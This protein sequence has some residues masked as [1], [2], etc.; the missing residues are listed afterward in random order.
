MASNAIHSTTLAELAFLTQSEVFVGRDLDVSAIDQATIHSNTKLVSSSVITNDGGLTLLQEQIEAL[1]AADFVSDDVAAALT[2]GATVRVHQGHAGGGRSGKVY[3]YLGTGRSLDGQPITFDLNTIDF[4]DL[5]LWVSANLDIL[6]TGNNLSASDSVAVGGIVASNDVR[7]DTAARITRADLTAGAVSLTAS[8]SGTIT[9]VIDSVVESSGDSAFGEGTTLAVNGTIAANSVLGSAEALLVDSVITTTAA[10]DSDGAVHVSAANAAQIDA[11]N[12]SVTH[13]GDGAVGAMLAFNSIGYVPQN[14]FFNSV[15]ALLGSSIANQQALR[16]EASVKD[17][18]ITAAGDV[19]VTAESTAEIEA[20]L[21]N[22]VTSVASGLIGANGF[23]ASALVASNRVASVVDAFVEFSPALPVADRSVTAAGDFTVAA[24]DHAAVTADVS[25]LSDSTATNDLG[26]SQVNALI[27]TL[28]NQY[29]YSSESGAKNLS[30]GDLVRVASTYELPPDAVQPPSDDDEFETEVVYKYM[31]PAGSVDLGATDYSNFGLWMKLNLFNVLP[32]GLNFSDSNSVGS[33]GLVVRNDVDGNATA[34]LE[35]AGAT[36]TGD[37]AVSATGDQT[38]RATTDSTVSSSGGSAFGGGTSLAVN[39]VIVTNNMLGDAEA[40]VRGSSITTLGSASSGAAGDFEVTADNTASFIA[41]NTSSTDSG[42]AS[43][44]VTLAYNRLGYSPSN[45]LFTSVEAIFGIV[46]GGGQP[47]GAKAWVEDTPIDVAGDLSVTAHNEAL[48]EAAVTNATASNA[49]AI[50]GATGAAAAAI[51]ASNLVD[52]DAAA[53]VNFTDAYLSENDLAHGAV[54]VAGGITVAAKDRAGIQADTTLE[55]I[56]ETTN[57]GLLGV[58]RDWASQLDGIYSFTSLSGT[59]SLIPGVAVRVAPGHSAGGV[60][61]GIYRYIGAP[62][63]IALGEENYARTSDWTRVTVEAGDVLPDLGNISD[64]DSIAVGLLLV[65]NDV[66]SD[67]DAAVTRTYMNASGNIQV[68]SLE[69]TDMIATASALVTSD[70]GGNDGGISL[71]LSGVIATNNVLGSAN[72]TIDASVIHAGGDF[73]IHAENRSTIDAS[74][75]AANESGDGAAGLTAAFNMLGVQ[76]LGLFSTLVDTVLGVNL[77]LLLEHPAEVKATASNTPIHAGGDLNVHADNFAELN[78]YT[79]NKVESAA[80][81]ITGSS[82]WAASMVIAA[83][84]VVS[85][86]EAGIAFAAG[87]SDR[88]V[89]AG[90]SVDV[91]AEN[92]AGNYSETYMVTASE[93]VNDG[94]AG[95]AKNVL[96]A[97]DPTPFDFLSSDGVQDIEFGQTVRLSKSHSGGGTPGSRYRYMGDDASVDLATADYDDKGYWREVSLVRLIETGGNVSESDSMAVG[98]ILTRNDVRSDVDAYLTDAVVTAADQVSV[99]ALENAT[100]RATV[101]AVATSSGGSAFGEGQSLAVNGVIAVN[102]VLSDAQAIVTGGSITTTAGDIVVHSENASFLNARNKSS[103]ESGDTGVGVTLA[104][105]TI[106][107]ETQD[108][109]TQ[110]FDALLGTQWLNRENPTKVHAI[111]DSTPLI[112]GGGISVTADNHATLRSLVSNEVASVAEAPRGAS[113]KAVGAVLSSNL[114]LIDTQASI[115]KTDGGQG[116]ATTQDGD[117]IVAATE[118]AA[119]I[120]HTQLAATSSATNDGGLSRILNKVADFLGYDF[121]DRSGTRTVA[122]GKLVLRDGA[123]FTSM[124]FAESITRG[125]RVLLEL[126]VEGG[127]KGDVF[128]FIGADDLEAVELDTFDYGD[129]AKWRKLTGDID[130]IYKYVGPSGAVNLG[131][132]DYADT[133]MWTPLPSIQPTELIPGLSLNLTDSDSHGFGGMIVRNAVESSVAALIDNYTL[134]AAGNV[135][136]EAIESSQVLAQGNATVTSSG[137]SIAGEGASLAL[138][139]VIATNAVQAAAEARIDRSAVTTTAGGDSAGDVDVVSRNNARIAAKTWST[140]EANGH[141]IGVTLAFNSVGYVPQNFLFNTIDTL[142][143]TSL[144]DQNPVTTH[145]VIQGTSVNAAGDVHVESL[146]DGGIDA[147]ITGAGKTLSVTPAGGSGTL[148]VGAILSMNKVATDTLATINSPASLTVGGD[149]E[150]I[151][152]DQARIVADV[153]QSSIAVGAGT[154]DSSAVAAGISWARNEVENHVRARIVGAGTQAAPASVT[155]GDLLVTTLRRGK[156]LATVTSTAVGVSAS[157]TNA[158]GISG[159]GSIGVNNLSGTAAAEISGSVIDVHAGGATIASDDES[160]IDALVRSIAGSVAISGTKS[161]AFALSLSVAKN[162]IGWQRTSETANHLSTDQP[163]FLGKNQTVKVAHGP[164]YGNV[165]KFVGDSISGTSNIQLSLENYD[166]PRRWEMVSLRAAEHSMLAS[167]DGT[168]LDVAGDLSVTA[169]SSSAI[170]ARVLAGSVAIGAAGTTGLAVAVGG[171]VSIN[172]IQSDLRASITNAPAILS[173]ASLPSIVASSI[174]VDADDAAN[175]ASLAGAA[176]IAGSFGGTTGFSGSIGLSLAFNNITGGA[177]ASLSD[178]QRVLSREGDVDVSAISRATPLFDFPL[179]THALTPAQLDDAAKQDDDNGDTAASDEAVVDAAADKVILD[180]LAAA[181]RAGGEQLADV[182]TLR[183]GWTFTS[184]QGLQAVSQGQSVKLDAGYTG[185]GVGQAVYEYIGSNATLNLSTQQYS[186]TSLWRRVAPELNL[187]VIDSGK[188]W[189]LVTGDGTSYT[190]QLQAGNP[191]RL[192]VSKTS[193]S[194]ISVAASLGIG[195]GGTTGVAI[196]GAGAVSINTIQ[197]DTSALVDSSDLQVAGDLNVSA[198]G[199][200]A[201][202]AAVIAASLAAGLGGTTGVGA[203]I[204]VAVSQNN[205]GMDSDGQTGTASISAIIRDSAVHATGAVNVSALADQRIAATVFSGSVAVAGGGTAGLAGS[206][207]GV[208]AENRIGSHVVASVQALGQPSSDSLTAAAISVTAADRSEITALA[209]AVSL[210]AGLG[211]TAGGAIS[212]GATYAKNVIETSVEASIVNERVRS[213][214]G[215]IIIDAQQQASIRVLAAAASLSLGI[216]GVAGVGVSGAGADANN[217]INT[218]TNAFASGSRL[219]SADN[220]I[221]SADNHAT[222]DAQILTASVGAG[223]GGK[224]GIGASIGVALA[225][226]I[227]GY[228]PTTVPYDALSG[229]TLTSLTTGTRVKVQEGVRVDEVYEYVGSAISAAVDLR[230]A[231][232]GDIQSWKRVDLTEGRSEVRAYLENSSVLADGKL[233]QSAMSSGLIQ[234]EVFAGSIAVGGG[235]VGVGVSGAGVGAENRMA[236]VVHA[237]ISGNASSRIEAAEIALTADDVSTIHVETGAASIAAAF[238]VVGVSVSIGAAVALNEIANDV[239]AYVTGVGQGLLASD[240]NLTIT[241]NEYA[242][243]SSVTQAASA[244]VAIGAVGV[245]V[246]GAGAGATNVILTDT[247]AYFEDTTGVVQGDATIEAVS[248]ST[249]RAEVLASS[250]ALAGGAV[251][252]G[253]SIGAA[254]AENYIGYDAQGNPQS[255]RVHTW[256]DQASLIVDGELDQSASSSALISAVTHAG[257]ASAA[258][259]LFGAAAAGAGVGTVNKVGQSIQSRITNTLPDGIQTAGGSL[260]ATD[261]ST[262]D[263]DAQASALAVMLGTGGAVSVGVSLAENTISNTTR[264]F[265]QN[266][267]LQ[268][269][270]NFVTSGG[271]QTVGIGQRVR[272]AG[273]YNPQQG[274]PG[275]IYQYLG[276]DSQYASAAGLVSINSG[277]RVRVSSG[278]SAGGHIGGVY[279]FNGI[280]DQHYTSDGEQRIEPGQRVRIAATYSAALAVP[281][282]AYQYIGAAAALINL[283][284]ANYLDTTQWKNVS[285][286]DLSTQDFTNTAVWTNLSSLALG[287][288][289]YLDSS[290]WREVQEGFAITATENATITASSKAASISGGLIAASGG[291]AESINTIATTTEAFIDQSSVTL[292]G[293]LLIDAQESAQA[294]SSVGTMNI[295]AGL[296]S[297]A[298]GGS[299]AEVNFNGIVASRISNSTV[300]ANDI[301]VLAQSTRKAFPTAMASMPAR[302]PSVSRWRPS[303]SSQR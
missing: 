3:K 271:T 107:Y 276:Q 95:I 182:D 35:G 247:S 32:E 203:S 282:A 154:A 148:N 268:N 171:V 292:S 163:S 136:V 168:V 67:V 79:S 206:G 21:S 47:V 139:V 151:A 277:D 297:V 190:L 170:D 146:A 275:A 300:V 173:D 184:G 77:D 140:V 18:P 188:S 270:A 245:A 251:A 30:L 145:A 108:L 17:T 246:S 6:P 29:K 55:S 105:N 241:A 205:I 54:T 303:T 72:A 123:D 43:A 114:V 64:S 233:K 195:I 124:E 204:G 90:G 76:P 15:D 85:E 158:K 4:E 39:G 172:T 147:R 118:A 225:R 16:T 132:A 89:D 283:S 180:R 36:V 69:Q 9:A 126:D 212:V 42:G 183:G 298:A 261:E 278:H 266:A 49:G 31:G 259:G 288:Q 7:G 197:S 71:A 34:Y 106:G 70:G 226:N 122:N 152:T 299:V 73:R 60:P 174:T 269:S 52:S 61:G 53:T 127:A 216:G 153:Q 274:R 155:G 263:A 191:G 8:K 1:T 131:E 65:R 164:N 175:I 104:Y 27:N 199:T 240:G 291:G 295:A 201:I 22:S 120:A 37:V 296:I 208:N 99:L 260:T 88:T 207:S 110:T 221:V 57:S 157:A 258:V 220:V 75:D 238:G 86:A 209:A 285:R 281:G 33:G 293:D 113:S 301:D 229:A 58:I 115:K 230:K 143:G 83:N 144:S 25:L 19:S 169:K 186:N 159:G 222:I 290:V 227:I 68:S 294:Y 109:L 161:P 181:L 112:A 98:G 93:S 228:R 287:S 210:A 194:A 13:S 280:V 239:A 94:F 192:E 211:G 116:T 84:R 243:I 213:T 235:T 249:I 166:D 187:S 286:V 224:A 24:D 129:A 250:A 96:R 46:L 56:S 102:L 66:R 130:M 156:I 149:L 50:F 2:F 253:V 254:T 133:S 45:L 28:A 101:D 162:Y 231:D 248:G 135:S 14:S 223:V 12:D 219:T 74:L 51:I 265:V 289:N 256:I 92:R 236:T 252:V 128:E 119:I 11:T 59:R 218:A 214:S 179:A 81:G 176:S 141:G 87:L 78:S 279:R 237:G 264:A 232:Y 10:G 262:I 23:S 138:N 80:S 103:V 26:T 273:G 244:S 100:V 178:N 177:L 302:W 134:M 217:F 121:T 20:T 41:I 196:S 48:M 111:V 257:S 142:L 267:T 38:L 189:L 117:L 242:T 5:D 150:V 82:G 40:Y 215:S 167:V 193:I 272:V 137:G 202:Q 185:G 62:T 284:T 63:S 200:A 160:L 255:S 44:G 198:A 165:Y 125:N 234:A 97:V 91:L